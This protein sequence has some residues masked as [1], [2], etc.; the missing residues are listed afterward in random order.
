MFSLLL[1]KA[2]P[3]ALTFV[4][5]TALGGLAG[6]SGG[7][8][9]GGYWTA[10]APHAH[11]SRRGCGSRRHY[12]VAESKPLVILFKP[13]AR[14]AGVGT[15]AVDSVRVN[16]TFGADGEVKEVRPPA[17]PSYA[18]GESLAGADVM[19][20]S[21]ERAARAIR[22]TPETIDGVP[23]TVEREVKIRFLAE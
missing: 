14:R 16:V 15:D 2:L 7:S 23:V 1:K 18:R 4:V 6:L 10:F 8:G 9:R 19:W 3:F 20:E 21:V 12:L 17:R 5:G 22:F 13:D 11:D